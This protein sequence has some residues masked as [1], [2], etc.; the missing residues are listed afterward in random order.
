MIGT[1]IRS[2]RHLYR[3]SDTSVKTVLIKFKENAWEVCKVIKSP[4]DSPFGECMFIFNNVFK[5]SQWG[6][7]TII[8]SDW[9]KKNVNCND[10]IGM[11]GRLISIPPTDFNS[12]NGIFGEIILLPVSFEKDYEKFLKENSKLINN[13]KTSFN[14][15]TRDVRIKRMYIYSD[16]SKNFFQ[17]AVNAYYKNGISLSTIKSILLW[18]ESYKQLSKNLSKGTITAYTSRDSIVPLLNE[19]SELRKEKRI[20]DSI[21]SFNTAQK[22]MLKEHELGE[23]IKQA[24]W[25]LSRLSE[26]KRLNFIKKMSSVEDFTELS[27]QL[28]FVTSVHFSWSKESF[29]DFINN[30][31]GIKY[32]KIFE[33]DNVVLIKTIDY[34]TVKQLGKTTNWCISKNKQYW[35]NYI[36]NYHGQTTQYMVFDFSK[37]EDDSLS[38]I[39]FTTTH[40]RGITS[41]HNFINEDLMGNRQ[42]DQVLL[43]SFISKFK[44]NRNIYG[45]L[46]EL[47]VDITLVVEYDKPPYNWD[48]NSLMDYLYECV[49]PE[50]VDML[51]SKDNKMVLS[52]TDQNLRYF[53]GDAYHDNIPSDFYSYQHILFIDF[54]K[55][56]YDIN[57]IQFGIIEEGYGDEDYC[58]GVFNERALNEGKNFDSLL[59]EYG[60]PYNTIRRTNNHL[61]RLRNAI[62]SFNTPMME[63]CMK[64]CSAKDLKQV[65][66]NDIGSDAFYDITLRS[67][68]SHMSFDYLN[69][70]YNNGI[71]LSEIMP[72]DYISDL[73]RHFA[74]DMR[75]VSRATNNFVNMEGI[76]DDEIKNFYELKIEK[77]E[78]TKYIGF[79]LAIKKIIEKEK[80]NGMDANTMYS[81]FLNYM[82][83]IGKQIDVFEQI[84]NLFKDD[85]DYVNCH[86]QVITYIARYTVFHGSQ[87]VKYYL[88]KKAESSD[89]LRELIERYTREYERMQGNKKHKVTITTSDITDG[90]VYVTVAAD[91]NAQEGTRYPF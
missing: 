41:A 59:I 90:G 65:I 2:I 91:T 52:V 35:N 63:D 58:S 76:T 45:I 4:K 46:A 83:G 48:K 84:F 60:L 18:N 73:I 14:F 17:W 79:Y 21:N 54:N 53:F 22:K 81:R 12:L 27:R 43:N 1:N 36:E 42:N 49:N 82:D 86:N 30:V 57:K 3:M 80:V 56:Q 11:Y 78:D 77:R 33:N 51:M 31:E 67:I 68:E 40:N 9:F 7:D 70:L 74:S 38:I 16:G 13:L 20:N 28:K 37:I 23:D 29:M 19:L 71:K 88:S 26:T 62:T 61:I 39:G 75:N 6:I 15:N 32:E 50:N 24:L 89:F 25:R 66:K 47:G 5:Q 44:E 34:E 8:T 69:L 64:E 10:I 55:S 72:Y 87:D 85:I